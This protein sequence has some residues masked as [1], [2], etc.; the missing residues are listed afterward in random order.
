MEKS[1]ISLWNLSA[2]GLEEYL[3]VITAAWAIRPFLLPENHR[4][5]LILTRDLMTTPGEMSLNFFIIY[6]NDQSKISI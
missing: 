2:F 5:T 1:K 4:Y 6:L 3:L